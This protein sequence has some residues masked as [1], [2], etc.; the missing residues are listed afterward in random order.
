MRTS[1]LLFLCALAACGARRPHVQGDEAPP[2]SLQETL[3]AMTGLVENDN[4]PTALELAEER[5]L[6]KAERIRFAQGLFDTLVHDGMCIRAA[7]FARAFGLDHAHGETAV[8]CV[9]RIDVIEAATVVCDADVDDA[10]RAAL[11]AEAWDSLDALP[12]DKR[13]AMLDTLVESTCPLPEARASA[14]FPKTLLDPAGLRLSRM[15]LHVA[16]SQKWGWDAQ[17]LFRQALAAAIGFDAVQR[18]Q[19]TID[20]TAFVPNDADL[21]SF[22]GYQIAHLRCEDAA[23]TVVS[24]KLPLARA[25]AIFAHPRCL[26]AAMTGI[27]WRVADDDAQAWFALAMK[28][29]KYR[30]ARL[31]AGKTKDGNALMEKVETAA[32]DALD[33]DAVMDFPPRDGEHAE[34]H[35]DRVLQGAL[36]RNEEWFVVRWSIYQQNQV[37]VPRR[38]AWIER[39]YLHALLRK[40]WKMAADCIAKHSVAATAAT[41]E[42]LVFEEA[43]RAEDAPAAVELARQYKLGNDC[44]RRAAVLQFRKNQEAERAK[45]KA[46]AEKEKRLR[47][48]SGDWFPKP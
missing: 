9:R 8:Q 31:L 26:G 40:E 45:A 13:F 34:Q 24:R 28:Y 23:M 35:Q 43:M 18:A 20:D 3:D 39:A 33:F 14:W 32:L 44:A 11:L 48:E 22:L 1:I 25:E 15:I 16:I 30:L 42:R 6:P 5:K 17:S 37:Q 2:P 47:K 19:E 38:D 27:G 36:D 21:D 29:R 12:A 41:A 4:I 7:K 10:Y 46:K